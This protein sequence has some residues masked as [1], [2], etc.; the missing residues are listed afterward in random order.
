MSEK[1]VRSPVRD[2]LFRLVLVTLASLIIAVN[3]KSFVQ[4][5]DLF[6]GGFTGLARL[7]QRAAWEFWGVDI[8][9]SPVYLLLNAVPAA[10]SFRFVGKKFTLYSCQCIVLVS[11]FTD[12]VPTI[13][14]TEDLLLICVFGGLITGFAVSLCLRARAT[15]GGTDFIAI[16]LVRTEE[17][18]CL[19]LYSGGQCGDAD[20]GRTAFRMGCGPCIP[21]F[22]SLPAL[23]PSVCWTRTAAG[24]PC[25]SSRDGKR[26]GACVPRYRIPTIPLL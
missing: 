14:I 19:E 24:P 25:L 15:S 18:R 4:A 10:I 13:P 5:G 1:A 21:S 8:P 12:L 9:F 26:W 20:G 11:I 3:M 22:S 6:P 17:Y 16:A 2:I 7:T 23:R